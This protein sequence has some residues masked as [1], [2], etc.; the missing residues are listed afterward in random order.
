M[1]QIPPDLEIP[2]SELSFTASR[3]SGPGGQHVNKTSSRITLRFDV[4]GS[5]SLDEEQRQRLLEVLATRIN[6]QQVLS[7]SSQ[8][9]RS[10]AANREAT[11]ERFVELL[12]GAL[13]LPTE[14]RPTRK[15]RR[16]ERR[17]LEDKRHRSQRKRERSKPAKWDD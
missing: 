8:R 14:R 17:R 13:E 9:H 3:S 1:I 15:S 7:I 6:R 11:V 2:E 5:P 12:S 16:V 4:G 10:Q